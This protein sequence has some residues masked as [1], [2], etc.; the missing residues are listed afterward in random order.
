M[1]ITSAPA[2]TCIFYHQISTTTEATCYMVNLPTSHTALDTFTL[3]VYS[4]LLS[5]SVCSICKRIFNSPE[6]NVVWNLPS[7][8]QSM[9][10]SEHLHAVSHP[11]ASKP[12]N[13][14]QIMQVV[15]YYVAQVCYISRVKLLNSNC[16][17]GQ[18]NHC[19][20][21]SRVRQSSKWHM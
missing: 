20:R 4:H 3:I 13:H 6:D 2:S 10:R 1:T 8:P 5:D 7:I 21:L 18:Q 11:S 15:L 14:G 9:S 12:L 19:P 16:T 17:A